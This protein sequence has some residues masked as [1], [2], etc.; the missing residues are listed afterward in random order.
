MI[1][2]KTTTVTSGSFGRKV[3]QHTAKLLLKR[4]TTLLRRE[5]HRKALDDRIRE[6]SKGTVIELMDPNI[7]KP[8]QRNHWYWINHKNT[9]WFIVTYS[10]IVRSNRSVDSSTATS[11]VG[12]TT[13][14]AQQQPTFKYKFLCSITGVEYI[15][16]PTN[17]Q[18]RQ[19]V[20][21]AEAISRAQK[22][23]MMV[24]L[25]HCKRFSY[26]T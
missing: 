24:E 14:Q 25:D 2:N 11:Q 18:I 19:Y 26:N 22:V 17:I 12:D 4:T 13:E 6:L 16:K 23:F 9:G 5:L 3:F 21:I 7:K 1:M 20:P 8:L 10:G 15:Y